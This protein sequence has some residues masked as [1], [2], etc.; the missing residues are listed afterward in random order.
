MAPDQTKLTQSRHA[1]EE[2]IET[3]DDGV[4]GPLRETGA[5]FA[6]LVSEG[7]HPDHALMDS[8]LNVLRQA[9][10]RATGETETQIERALE[11]AEAY[12]EEL[13]RV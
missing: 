12:R 2:A 10:E 9:N 8:H 1:L 13:P 7:R 4:R 5:A 11:H 6:E 3:A